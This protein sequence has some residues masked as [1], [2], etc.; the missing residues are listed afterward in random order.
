MPKELSHW[1]LAELAYQS[2]DNTELKKILNEFKSEYLWGAVMHDAPFYA[3]NTDNGDMILKAGKSVHGIPPNNTLLPFLRLAREYDTSPTPALLAFICGAFSHMIADIVFHPFVLYY[4]GA[5]S[6]RHLR[7]EALLDCYFFQKKIIGNRISVKDILGTVSSNRND[8]LTWMAL[9]FD[10]P[11]TLSTELEKTLIRHG[12]IQNLFAKKWAPFTLSFLA[13][14]NPEK[15]EDHKNLFYMNGLNC[16]TPFFHSG[17]TYKHPVTGAE[18]KS[19]IAQLTEEMIQKT[20]RMFRNVNGKDSKSKLE[21]LFSKM[22]PVSLE[23]GMNSFDDPDRPYHDVNQSIDDLV[24]N[25]EIK[26]M[27]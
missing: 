27:S 13:R 7:L 14:I 8:V 6:N 20:N 1:T 25:G 2:T 3:H 22:I 19:S 9:F 23:T 17:F 5:D 26:K 21:E 15:Y 16:Y 12:K 11:P 10:I 4:S 24:F 18:S